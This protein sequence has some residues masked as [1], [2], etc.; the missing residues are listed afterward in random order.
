MSKT[1]SLKLQDSIF[2]ETEVITQK[3]KMPRNGYINAAVAF[4]NKLKKR[5]LLQKELALE[6]KLVRDESLAI[7][8]TFESFE[9][10]IKEN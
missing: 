10:D 6:S 7:L 1:L 3:L 9:D 2:E 8:E 4:Y 5:A